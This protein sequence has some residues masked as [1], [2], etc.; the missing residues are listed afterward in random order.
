MLNA[1]ANILE[2]RPTES[3]KWIADI[4]LNCGSLIDVTIKPEE[5]NKYTATYIEVENGISVY[6][7]N[8]RRFTSISE[9]IIT[10]EAYFIKRI[11]CKYCERDL[12]TYLSGLLL[13]DGLIG[14]ADDV[15]AEEYMFLYLNICELFKF[16]ITYNANIFENLMNKK[17]KE[18]KRLKSSISGLIVWL[19]SKELNHK[20]ATKLLQI[21]AAIDS[22]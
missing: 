22:L 3:G 15:M 4:K 6:H 16:L 10:I 11:T 13:S 17:P 2:Y 14:N 1:L 7:F 12:S 20:S 18:L 21:K 8:D 19:L 5:D 9:A